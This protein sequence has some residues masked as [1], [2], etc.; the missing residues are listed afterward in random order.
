MLLK[1]KRRREERSR[2]YGLL[3]LKTLWKES[4]IKLEFLTF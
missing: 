4:N 3:S 1:V 2:F